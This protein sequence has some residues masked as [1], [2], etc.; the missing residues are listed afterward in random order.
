MG[1]VFALVA[2]LLGMEDAAAAEDAAVPAMI[3]PGAVAVW[4]PTADGCRIGDERL[5]VLG[6]RCWFPVD[7]LTPPGTRWTIE[8][9]GGMVTLEVGAYPYPAQQ[10]H[11]DD[12]RM[13]SPDAASLER[14]AAENARIRALWPL[15]TPARFELPLAPPLADLPAGG[16]FG[17][18]RVFNGQPR[19]PHSGADYGAPRGTPVLA[20]AP[21]RVVL[22]ED[23]YFAGKSVYIDH[24]DGLITMSFHLDEIRVAEGADVTTGDVIGTV[25]STGRASGPH[26]HVGVRWRGARVDPEV[27][28]DLRRPVELDRA[29]S[30]GSIRE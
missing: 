19:N 6:G 14:I 23:H 27:L 7:L 3:A 30:Q 11:L 2:V 28:M 22:A 29:A 8:T 1:A 24:G 9:A 21:G 13:V 18:R 4:Q 17:S 5:P 26:L 25:G 15:R 10:I 12:E 16:R 20:M